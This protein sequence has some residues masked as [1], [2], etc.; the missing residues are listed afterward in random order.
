MNPLRWSIAPVKTTGNS[1]VDCSPL[2]DDL[3]DGQLESWRTVSLSLCIAFVCWA[4]SWSQASGQV[5]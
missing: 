1:G 3:T 5:M 2:V 4:R